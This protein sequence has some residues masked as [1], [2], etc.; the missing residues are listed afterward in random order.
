[1]ELRGIGIDI[2]DRRVNGDLE[3]LRRELDYFQACAFDVIEL[4]SSGLFFVFNGK[5]HMKRARAIEQVLRGYPFHY[6]LHLPDC[7]NLGSLSEWELE[8]RIFSACMDFAELVDATILVYHTGQDYLDATSGDEIKRAMEQE[9]AALAEMADRAKTAAMMVTV[10]NQNPHPGEA[11]FLADRGIPKERLKV[12]HPGLFPD[13]IGRQIEEINSPN[14][15][16]TLDIG[17]LF[18]AV[19]LTGQGFLSTVENQARR[20]KH[21][22]VNDNFGKNPSP[23]YSRMEQTLYGKGDCH[24]PLGMG[25]LPFRECFK[26]LGSYTGYV[27]FEMRPAYRDCLPESIRIL[28]RMIGTQCG[29]FE[30]H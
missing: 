4:T 11:Q 12:V 8:K 13:E 9:T 29:A 26:R 27:I 22:H 19:E 2:D 30:T 14:L 7:L 5:L 28:K 10:E 1:M 16:M 23:L 21:L 3:V 20:I 25:A 15:G 17:H 6:T 18:L 24:L